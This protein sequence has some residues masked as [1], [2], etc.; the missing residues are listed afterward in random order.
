MNAERERGT[1]YPQTSICTVEHLQSYNITWLER[2]TAQKQREKRFLYTWLL[3]TFYSN[4][5]SGENDPANCPPLTKLITRLLLK[6]TPHCCST[7][8]ADLDWSQN[9]GR[10]TNT[11]PRIAIPEGLTNP[12]Y[13]TM[14]SK[15][16]K[17]F[18]HLFSH[19]FQI[20]I[21]WKEKDD[22]KKKNRED[23]IFLVWMCWRTGK[24][25]YENM[26]GEN[27]SNSLFQRRTGFLA[28]GNDEGTF[29]TTTRRTRER[30][31]PAYHNEIFLLLLF[32]GSRP[33]KVLGWTRFYVMYLWDPL[34]KDFV[35]LHTSMGGFLVRP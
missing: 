17:I 35:H 13:L 26:K 15:Q 8:T 2:I 3:S 9:I 22:Y 11:E 34:L 14:M 32:E 7:N 27:K 29:L 4:L 28:K 6:Q 5:A 24:G 33:Q 23:S 12:G 20:Q 25:Q 21:L 1:C 18:K 10:Q 16:L 31:K 30:I 19:Y